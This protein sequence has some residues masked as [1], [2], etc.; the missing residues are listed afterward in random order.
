MKQ[1]FE[2]QILNKSLRTNST[3]KQSNVKEFTGTESTNKRG[4][5]V[6]DEERSF[7]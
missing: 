3:S 1:W 5:F 4:S 2:I 6:E 7:N